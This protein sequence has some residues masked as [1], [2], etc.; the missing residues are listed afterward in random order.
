[1]GAITRGNQFDGFGKVAFIGN[2]GLCGFQLSI[3]CDDGTQPP[4]SLEYDLDWARLFDWKFILVGY[5]CGLLIGISV[6]YILL[7][8]KRLAS[9][10]R[11][12]G[13]QRWHKLLGRQKKKKNACFNNKRRN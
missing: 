2:M 7:S 9:F 6:C 4:S 11:K 12:F 10:M 8:D 5:G 13:G 3:T 1:M